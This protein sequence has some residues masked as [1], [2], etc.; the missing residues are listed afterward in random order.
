[1]VKILVGV[2]SSLRCKA[3][4]SH[5]D[6]APTLVS[7]STAAA[8][9]KAA[10]TKSLSGRD[11]SALLA[12][13]EKASLTAIRDGMLFCYN[14]FAYIDGDFLHKAVAMLQQPD[15]KAKLKEAVSLRHYAPRFQ[16]A[17]RDPQRVRRPLSVH[18]LFLAQAA[19][20]ARVARSIFQA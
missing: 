19:Q 15:G 10:I 9:K 7:L 13:P 18:A 12:A 8:D 14:M 11:F 2:P 20:Q 5:L 16:Q 1:L 6:I 4:T 17:R 3:V